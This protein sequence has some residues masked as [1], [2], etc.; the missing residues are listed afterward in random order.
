MYMYMCTYMYMYMYMYN[1]IMIGTV[2]VLDLQLYYIL[3]FYR[4]VTFG[5]TLML[6]FQ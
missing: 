5:L 4:R 3:C 2:C 6:R 1:C